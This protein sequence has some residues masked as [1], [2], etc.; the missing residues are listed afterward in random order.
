MWGESQRGEVNKEG[1]NQGLL[2]YV[3]FRRFTPH[4]V[5]ET[6]EERQIDIAHKSFPLFTLRLSLFPSALHLIEVMPIFLFCH[7][8]VN[9]R[10]K[11]A[12]CTVKYHW[13]E[14]PRV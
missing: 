11:C 3:V 10:A 8:N 13:Q 9:D 6:L 4:D 5:S 12:E 1:E 2:N 7:L 14:Q